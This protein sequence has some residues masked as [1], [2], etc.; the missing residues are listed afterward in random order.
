[1]IRALAGRVRGS[2]NSRS[3]VVSSREEEGEIDGDCFQADCSSCRYFGRV[4][5]RAICRGADPSPREGAGGLRGVGGGEGSGGS[6][7]EAAEGLAGS[8]ALSGCQRHNGDTG[9]G[10]TA[11]RFHGR[12]DYGHVGATTIRWIFSREAVP[13][14]GN[15]RADDTANVTAISRRRDRP[16]AESCSDS[17]GNQRHCWKYGS[18]HAGGNGREP[19]VDGGTG[20]R[21]WHSRGV[22]LGNAR[23]QLWARPRRPSYR[24]AH[25]A[26]TRED[27][28]TE[29]LDQ[30][31]RRG[32][33]PCISRLFFRH[34]GRRRA[35]QKGNQRGWPPSQ[36]CRIRGDGAGG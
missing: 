32:E 21:Q 18:D 13:G 8:S 5:P 2:F 36:R 34:G 19:G 33:R 26:P 30:K 10:R 6:A 3:L 12:F 25:Q 24:Y 11:R 35:A 15:W 27:S 7:R 1:M 4:R 16:A 22:V 20:P 14:E 17:G 31:V 29:H 9:E 23:K 28:R